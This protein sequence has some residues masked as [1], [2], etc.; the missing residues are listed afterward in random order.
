MYCLPQGPLPVVAQI[1]KT[2]SPSLAERKRGEE[3]IKA[4]QCVCCHVINGKGAL[5]SVSLDNLKR[6][7]KFVVDHL[8]DPEEHVAKNA[9]AFNF[10][11][12]LMPSHQLT[13][14]E[15]RSMAAYLLH[16]DNQRKPIPK[17]QAKKTA[18][19]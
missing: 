5:G 1:K 19:H 8:L 14:A 16:K 2:S 18:E 10:D 9:A 6:S 11:P 15:A 3:L 13:V 4:Y 7:P 17:K 12:N